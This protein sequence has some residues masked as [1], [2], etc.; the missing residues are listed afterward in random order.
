MLRTVFLLLGVAFF[1][2]L[3]WYLGPSEI[4]DLLRRIGWSSIPI[5]LLYAAHHA[6]RAL[7]LYSCVLQPGMIRYRDANAHTAHVRER[8]ASRRILLLALFELSPY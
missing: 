5:F 3:L 6:T 4:F 2:L 8:M 1:A 7:A